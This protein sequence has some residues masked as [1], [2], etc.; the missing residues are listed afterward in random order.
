MR[1]LFFAQLK[2]ATGLAEQEWQIETPLS[3][4]AMWEALLRQFPQLS[5]HRPTVR[6]A[7]NGHYLQT[8]EKLL[9]NDEVALI[10]PVSGG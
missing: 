7:R 9:A 10:P 5:A 6:I 2:T 8:G 3:E 4:E 1:L